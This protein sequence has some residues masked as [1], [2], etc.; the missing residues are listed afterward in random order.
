MKFISGSLSMTAHSYD[1]DYQQY[2]NRMNSI[3][4]KI[5][6][7]VM[8]DFLSHYSENNCLT[9]ICDYMSTIFTFSDS[10]VSFVRKA[11]EPSILTE[12]IQR[13]LLDD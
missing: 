1:V 9:Y 6:G 7:K 11:E 5:G 13:T 3:T 2:F 10:W 12:W 8:F 4:A